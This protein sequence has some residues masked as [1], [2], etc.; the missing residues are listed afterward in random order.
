MA[1]SLGWAEPPAGLGGHLERM[2]LPDGFTGCASGTE[3]GVQ[4]R[5]K[6]SHV[7]A[8]VQ[9]GPW[10]VFWALG[11]C[12]KAEGAMQGSLAS[13]A[14]RSMLRQHAPL[15]AVVISSYQLHPSTHLQH[16]AP[17]AALRHGARTILQA[18]LPGG[19][20]QAKKYF[21]YVFFGAAHPPHV[22]Q[23]IS[24]HHYKQS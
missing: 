10:I 12:W 13:Q 21:T 19:G 18:P 24:H 8:R 20:F 7:P 3:N 2:Q 11:A 23:R 5:V 14:L 1:E 22:E 4:I 17:G 15:G 16:T 6:C 9:W